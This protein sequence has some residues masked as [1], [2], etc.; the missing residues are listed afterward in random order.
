MSL[1]LFVLCTSGLSSPLQSAAPR[2]SGAPVPARGFAHPEA[3]ELAGKP[4]AVFPHFQQVRA[5]NEGEHIRIAL[6][7]RSDVRLAK[8]VVDVFLIEH[9]ELPSFLAGRKLESLTGPPLS[10]RL[11]KGGVQENTFVLDAG[12]LRGTGSPDADGVVQLGRGY[13][14]VVDVNLNATLDSSDL[15][16]GSLTEA[17]FYVVED[18][19]R[20]ERAGTKETGPYRVTEV[21]V[22]GGSTFTQQD[23]YFPEEVAALGALPLIVVSHG[24][25]HNYQWYDHIGYHMA[26]WGY[27]VMSHANNT[28]PGIE[29]AST[30]T[31]RN[32]ELFLARL[33]TIAGG[34]LLGHVDPHRI[35]WIG[36]SR[37]GEGVA[38]AYRRL[39][40]GT[41][42]AV[43]YGLDDIKLVSSIAPT[44]FLGPNVSDMGAAPYHL[45]TGGADDDVNGCANCD[46]CQ[47]FHLLERADGTRFSTSLHGVGHGDFHDG[48]GSSVAAGP[49]R[50]G[51]RLTHEIMR[52]YLLP[53]VQ[54]NL[55][56]NPACLDY[57]SRQWEE[58]RALGAP[59]PAL[60]ENR[61]V[62]VDLMYLP[63]PERGRFVIDDFQ[64]E[65]AL[66]RSSSGAAV[67]HSR[68]LATTLLEGRYDDANANFTDTPVDPMNGMTLAGPGDTSAGAVLEW[69]GADEW[70]TFEVP[71]A[72]RDA[73][74]QRTLSFRAAQ[75]TR[76]GLTV[77]ELGDLD[78]SV[79]L[80]D[81][82]L[83]SST[84]RISAYGGGIEEPYQRG[85]CGMGNGWANEFETIR[86][87]LAD[88]RRDGKRVDL[89]SL[90]AV[91]FLFGPSHGSPAG[92]I[93]LDEIV[94]TQD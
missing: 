42:I 81:S 87:P 37:G 15:L 1:V 17:G 57:L 77:A 85:S 22:D 34:A 27:V 38:R 84:I 11:T 80:S 61:C 76:H 65:P 73:S 54:F 5:F 48:G 20:F 13:D 69:S 25:G 2:G 89:A 50:V 52:A 12:T 9:A 6:D 51:R 32:T 59:D 46:I 41:P 74:G 75:A 23:V 71:A 47:T 26:S 16:D 39:L 83:R 43:S 44:D 30:T 56:G 3:R 7:P 67:S 10:V 31:L 82:A 60:A 35:V 68:G 33:D 88:F 93:A 66:S 4:L 63:G 18:F 14:V 28:G 8:R 92:R 49:C 78:F 29:S 70:L 64:T 72:G 79:Q 24:N 19:V 55:D 45:W 58:F 40:D 62:V 36:H 86:I 91:T 21:L 90:A 53:L 94:F